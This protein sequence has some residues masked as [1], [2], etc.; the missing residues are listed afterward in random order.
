M[1]GLA[2][3]PTTVALV[4]AFVALVFPLALCASC[5]RCYAESKSKR[6]RDNVLNTMVT[7]VAEPVI[8]EAE[9]VPDGFMEGEGH[10]LQPAL[11]VTS[12]LSRTSSG[13]DLPLASVL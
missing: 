1:S 6:Y 8:S 13:G 7:S 5:L 12:R 9:V 2:D 11:V 3:I 4:A 10:D